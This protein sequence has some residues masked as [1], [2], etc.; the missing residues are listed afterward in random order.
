MSDRAAQRTAPSLVEVFEAMARE[1]VAL[2][3]QAGEACER[4]DFP[5][6]EALTERHWDHPIWTL[7]RL[8]EAH[9]SIER[10]TLEQVAARINTNLGLR[11]L[12]RTRRRPDP[13]PSRPPGPSEDDELL[14]GLLPDDEPTR[15]DLPDLRGVLARFNECDVNGTTATI[16]RRFEGQ[17]PGVL[18][19]FDFSWQPAAENDPHRPPSPPEGED[20]LPAVDGDDIKI[21]AQLCKAAPRL[22]NNYALESETRI[23]RKTVGT[24]LKRL[25]EAGLAHRPKGDRKGAAITQKGIDLLAKL[26]P[27]TTR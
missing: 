9:T 23:S 4:E 13:W 17:H 21:L 6:G 25:I 19:A 26:K 16:L 18:A 12:T 22:L 15:P 24:R 7:F 20:T 5:A 8:V 10:E 14:A 11:P 1:W 2:S 3:Q 27:P